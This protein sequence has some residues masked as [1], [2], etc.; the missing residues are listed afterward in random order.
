MIESAMFATECWGRV[1]LVAGRVLLPESSRGGHQSAQYAGVR[2]RPR[3]P[4]GSN[5]LGF[6]V[7][8]PIH[9]VIDS[10]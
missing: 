1:G 3:T 2:G 9:A 6:R 7:A 8:L 4:A 10:E 5:S